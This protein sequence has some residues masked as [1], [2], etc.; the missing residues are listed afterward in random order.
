MDSKPHVSFS[1]A[2]DTQSS[3]GS[4][5]IRAPLTADSDFDY[6]SNS[7]E[8]ESTSGGSTVNSFENNNNNDDS[9]LELG[10]KEFFSGDEEFDASSEM[11]RLGLDEDNDTDS[12]ENSSVDEENSGVSIGFMGSF[13]SNLI[14]PIAQLSRDN[15][16][17]SEMFTDDEKMVTDVEDGEF[18]G[19][20]QVESDLED[21]IAKGKGLSLDVSKFDDGIP[22]QN[23]DDE[24]IE[25]KPVDKIVVS[26][27]EEFKVEETRVEVGE[28][29][30]CEST[31]C[32]NGDIII[33]NTGNVSLFKTADGDTNSDPF[34]FPASVLGLDQEIEP[35]VEAIDKHIADNV[36]IYDESVVQMISRSSETTSTS[37]SKVAF[38]DQIW[39]TSQQIVM[40]SD[41]AEAKM[42]HEAKELFNSAAL[43]TLS[44]DPTVVETDGGGLT[45]ISPCGSR[46][47]SL[48]CAAHSGSSFHSLKVAPSNMDNIS[49]EENLSD[50]DKLFER[51]QLIRVKF[52]RLIH[53]LGHSPNDPMVAPVLYRLALASGN[54]FCQE[55]TLE[56]SMKTAMQLE[57]EGK[58]ELDFSLTLLV[59]GK[60]GVGK[61]ASINSIFCEQKSMIDAFEPATTTVKE[62]VG[63]FDGV[64]IKIFDTPGLRSPVTEEA[65]NCKLLASIKR[66]IR[67]FPP[68]VVLYV[69]RLDTYDRDLTDFLLLKSL[70]DSLGSSIWE[71]AIVTLTH[72]ASASPEGPVGEPLSFEAFVAQRSN[73]VHRGI[74]QAVGDLLLMNPSMMQPVALVENHPLCQGDRNGEFLLPNGKTWRSQLLLLCYSVKILSEA[75][76]LSKPQDPLDHHKLFSS[77]IHSPPLPYFLSSL[78]QS[79]PHPKLPNNQGD[80]DVILEIELGDSSNYDEYDKHPPFKS[81]GR[82]QVDKLCK[83]QRKPYFEENDYRV[84]LL[85]KKQWRNDVKRLME[86]KKKEK[87][88]DGNDDDDDVGDNA[89]IEEVD[90]TTISVPLPEM[91]LP[92]SFNGDNPTYLYRFSESASQLL[93][94]PVLD[95]QVWDRD[96]GYDGVSLER[97]L[98]IAGYLPG[99]FAVQITKD[100][101]EFNVHLDSSVHSKHRGNGSTMLGFNIQ[102]VGKQLAYVLRT[103]TRFRNFNINRTT[104]GLS[105]TFFGGNM[106]TGVKI[107]DWISIGKRL[108]LAGNAGAVACQGQAAYGANIEIRLK[109]NFPV[110]QIQ[111]ILGLSFVKWRHDPALMDNLQSQFSIGCSSSVAVHGGLKHQ[112]CGQITL[113]VSSSEQLYMT[114]ASLIPIAVS[115][116]RMIYPGSDIKKF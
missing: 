54:P 101:R 13:I 49:F 45:V 15:E 37:L 32:N 116:F 51:L 87:D 95:S 112:F 72:A 70:T 103:E 110:E 20:I 4:L 71:K 9:E 6:G 85:Q 92:P 16:G 106:A 113:K 58:D 28:P 67:K 61:S 62:I 10:I 43:A 77:Q 48:D 50:E 23:P 111:T 108:V 80:E 99:A 33:V 17:F 31:E 105:G 86:T 36:C 97:S 39:I 104:V 22:L 68:D 46:V 47:F 98:A 40:D 84:K 102:T 89:N 34:K 25:S 14:V 5:L 29:M 18:S 83:E 7:N 75:S 26:D 8:T 109:D 12:L 55:F 100:K 79:R 24:R 96:I 78:L 76:C 74:S 38:E 81:L 21:F 60:T 91:V 19:V 69:D 64:K 44:E 30:S 73:V 1:A 2:E 57:A 11:W 93:T 88:G 59:L 52:L 114:F 115:I 63:T 3:S 56:S 82:S 90:P 53:R 107:E 27:M 42:E 35:E 41:E 65:T 94:R 66:S